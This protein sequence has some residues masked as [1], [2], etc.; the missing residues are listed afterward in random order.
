MS[1]GVFDAEVAPTYDADVADMFAPEVLG[2]T[3]DLLADLARGGRALELAIGTGRVALALAERGV[4]VAGIE[5]SS[6]M[7]RELRAKPGGEAL[8]VAI[9]DMTTTRVPGEF[10]LVYLVFNTIGNLLTQDEQV[11]CFVNAAVHLAPGGAFVIELEVPAV[12]RLPPG[13]RFVTFR[14]DGGYAGIDE[15]DLVTQRLDSRHYSVND[16]GTGGLFVTPQRYVWPSELDLMARIAGLTLV[17]RWADWSRS[18]FTA[19]S[20]S[21]VS[22]WV[23]D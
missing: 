7:V 16:D 18:P 14:V 11:A 15:Y 2:P 3:A 20:P 8:E 5:L 12:R 17:E 13:E 10:S 4:D 9:G 22:V 19:D 21:H 6:A 23:K 1:D